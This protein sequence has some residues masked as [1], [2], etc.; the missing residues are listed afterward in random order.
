[1]RLIILVL[2]GLMLLACTAE[3]KG[4]RVEVKG[5]SVEIGP[6][7]PDFCPPGQANKGRC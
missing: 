6:D 2:A 1:M 7:H 3:V 4:P 5:P